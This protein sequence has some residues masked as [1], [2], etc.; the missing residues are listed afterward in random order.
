MW[1]T[2][3]A[4]IL[5]FFSARNEFESVVDVADLIDNVGF[6]TRKAAELEQETGSTCLNGSSTAE[7][8]V[9]VDDTGSKEAESFVTPLMYL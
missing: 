9:G 8:T 1:S 4:L 5:A 2:V 7:D 6:L 3:R